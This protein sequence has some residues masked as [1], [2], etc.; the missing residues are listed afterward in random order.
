MFRSIVIALDLTPDGDRALAVAQVL[1]AA[2]ELPV[3]LLTVSSPHMD[4]ATDAYELSRRAAAHGWPPDAFTITHDDDVP[5]AI[6]QHLASREGSL[7]VMATSAKSTLATRFLGS[8]TEGVLTRIERPVLLVGPNV[9]ADVELTAPTL[10]VLID[11]GDLAEAT[12][13]AI[14]SWRR[15]FHGPAPVLAMLTDSSSGQPAAPPV[16]VDRY[17]ALLAAQDITASTLPVRGE[18][19]DFSLTLAADRVSEPVF[20]ATSVR[21]TDA[22][23]RGRSMTQRLVHA[24]VS[25]VLVVPARY[26]PWLPPSE[27]PPPTTTL[28]ID[29][30]EELTSR[31]CWALL[32]STRVGRLAVC[33]S[34]FPGIFPVNFVVDDE[35]IVFR[36]AEGTKLAALTNVHVA[37]EIDDYD[38]DS[39]QA[40]SVI[41]E[42]R[43]AE[44]TEADDRDRAV[45]LPLFPWQVAPKGH[46]VRITPDTVSGRRF[47]AVYAARGA[48]PS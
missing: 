17:V 41:V 40:S 23:T 42:G 16:D 26:A 18:D 25:P 33:I 34:G 44:V 29:T 46:F 4:D 10:V 7:L 35:T 13:P 1:A 14:A 37:F 6:V 9:P 21:W 2:S 12:V 8:V 47:H 11:S 31:E 43:A 5:N 15:T 48:Q 24:S 28:P 20:V 36:T 19:L 27:P 39:G 38:P 30:I 45:G 22:Q 3:E 32:G